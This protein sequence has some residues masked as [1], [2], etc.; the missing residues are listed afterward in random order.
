MGR[1]TVCPQ[2][3]SGFAKNEKSNISKKKLI[4]FKEFAKILLGLSQYQLRK[5]IEN[6]GQCPSGP[7]MELSL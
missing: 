6:G 2:K 7:C 3:R 5:A 4:A 1:K